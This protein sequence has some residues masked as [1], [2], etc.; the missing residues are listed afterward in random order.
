MLVVQDRSPELDLARRLRP[1]LE[2]VPLGA[3]RRLRGH[4]QLLADRVDGRVGHL[5]E[6]LLE[7]VVQEL[8][9]LREDRERRVVAHRAH[10]L[11]RFGRHR[12]H[13]QSQVL[14]G[15]A[16]GVL[17]QLERVFLRPGQ[18]AARGQVLERDQLLPEPDGVGPLRRDA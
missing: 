1:G 15:V 14:R 10:G 13:Q 11:V 5:G 17:A 18:V 8:G 2:Q 9:P 12:G 7:V 16:E 4:D 3:D 6:E